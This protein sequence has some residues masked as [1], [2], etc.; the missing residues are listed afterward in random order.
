MG[1]RGRPPSA[2]GEVPTPQ[3]FPPILNCTIV[4]HT[5]QIIPCIYI[6]A[7]IIHVGWGVGGDVVGIVHC[8]CPW[9]CSG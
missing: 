4:I 3:P 8:L 7:P 9:P 6:H 1:H 2:S 5:S